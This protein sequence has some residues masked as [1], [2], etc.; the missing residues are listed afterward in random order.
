MSLLTKLKLAFFETSPFGW[1]VCIFQEQIVMLNSEARG[2]NRNW[3]WM[4]DDKHINHQDV[5]FNKFQHFYGF[6]SLFLP[7]TSPNENILILNVSKFD[8]CLFM[9]AL[10]DLQLFNLVMGEI[11][12]L[13]SILRSERQIFNKLLIWLVWKRVAICIV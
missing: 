10:F 8:F 13:Q 6:F 2:V 3:S 4:S 5:I 1:C 9:T 11:F 12:S 7:F